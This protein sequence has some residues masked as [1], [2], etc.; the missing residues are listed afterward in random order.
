MLIQK[1]LGCYSHPFSELTPPTSPPSTL[2]PCL[3]LFL[4]SNPFHHLSLPFSFLSNL[5]FLIRFNSIS[6]LPLCVFFII[7]VNPLHPCF[8]LSSVPFIHATSLPPNAF[9]VFFFSNSS[10]YPSVKNLKLLIHPPH[11]PIPYSACYPLGNC[12]CFQ[13]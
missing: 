2:S 6:S 13:Q 12:C 3:L 4:L 1:C 9:I 7:L 5:V 8:S 10:M 11:N